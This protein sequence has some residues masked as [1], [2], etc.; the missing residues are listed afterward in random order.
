MRPLQFMPNERLW[1]TVKKLAH[2]S[3][4]TRIAVS[5]Y[6]GSGASKMLPLRRGDVLLCAL[7]L[8]NCRAGNVYPSELRRLLK[9]GVKVFAQADL[10]A[11]VYLFGGTGVVGSANMS[12]N[13]ERVLDEAAILVRGALVREIREWV[14]QRL[15]DPVQMGF[16]EECERV[17]RAPRFGAGVPQR[18]KKSGHRSPR[19]GSVWLVKT[20]PTEFPEAEAATVQAGD[21][22][23]RRRLGRP[24]ANDL[25]T[26]RWPHATRIQPGD[27]LIN[28]HSNGRKV[29]VLPHGKVV[30][31]KV[32]P[33]RQGSATYLYFEVPARFRTLGFATFADEC[34]Q[35]GYKPPRVSGARLVQNRLASFVLRS[36]TSPERLRR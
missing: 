9:K 13:S 22:V 25:D 11:K 15:G 30:H 21:K 3:R 7:S 36:V 19:E 5:A 6:I 34:K 33:A 2:R 29:R 1:P 26:I 20:S 10:H 24:R 18:G 14:K 28:L 12:G 8:R 4:G 31:R 27:T 35:R 32:V 16:L 17:F 23:A